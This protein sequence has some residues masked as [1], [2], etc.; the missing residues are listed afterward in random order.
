MARTAWSCECVSGS[1]GF[2]NGF[3]SVTAHPDVANGKLRQN[4][5]S[6]AE[7]NVLVTAQS[8]KQRS[9]Q[10]RSHCRRACQHADSYHHNQH[11][12]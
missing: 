7:P 10:N 2:G 3:P 1:N 6:P 5:E 12:Q 8:C 9:S 4:Y 11:H